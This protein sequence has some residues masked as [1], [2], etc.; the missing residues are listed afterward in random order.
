[1]V[2]FF[3]TQCNSDTTINTSLQLLLAH[4][5]VNEK[6]IGAPEWLECQRPVTDTQAYVKPAKLRISV[7]LFFLG[8][9]LE[10]NH[11]FPFCSHSTYFTQGAADNL[12]QGRDLWPGSCASFFFFC[13]ARRTEVVW[14]KLFTSVKSGG[15]GRWDPGVRVRWKE[16]KWRR[17][18]ER[19]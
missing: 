18:K 1:M 14:K 11:S 13:A 8:R 15:K 16:S 5:N 17:R 9:S 6:Q 19:S 7:I 12:Q 3:L 10:F 4:K 2:I